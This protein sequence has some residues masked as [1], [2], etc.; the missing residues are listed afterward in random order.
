MLVREFVATPSTTPLWI[1]PNA[2][3][4]RIEGDA[5]VYP[6]DPD[7]FAAKLARFADQGARILGDCCGSS[8]AHLQA[9]DRA[10][11]AGRRQAA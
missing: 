5:V 10:L 3:V 1:K 8:P 11:G 7:S 9:L 6:E 4:P 2:G